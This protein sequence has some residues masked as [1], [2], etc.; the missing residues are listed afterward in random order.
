MPLPEEQ[1]EVEITKDGRWAQEPWKPQLVVKVGDK[2]KISVSIA[3][4]QQTAG[5]CKIIKVKPAKQVKKKA[6]KNPAIEDKKD[7]EG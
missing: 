6:D 1:V 3:L 7:A 2:V 5:K 4:K